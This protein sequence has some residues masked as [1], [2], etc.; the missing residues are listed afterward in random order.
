MTA[1]ITAGSPNV[2]VNGLKVARVSDTTDGVT[3]D[4]V[5]DIAGA[6]TGEVLGNMQQA[7]AWGSATL[8]SVNGAF[9]MSAPLTIPP[10]SGSSNT[11]NNMVPTIDLVQQ[12]IG[13][14][15]GGVTFPITIGQGG[16]G[17]NNTATSGN[18]L[19][20][21]GTAFKS[22]TLHGDA[23]VAANG[24]ILVSSSEGTAFGTAA[25]ANTTAFATDAEGNL[26]TS[27]V[28]P[29]DLATVAT[30]GAYND[31]SGKPTSLPPSGSAGGSLKGTYPNPTLTNTAVVAGT[32]GNT[33]YYGV[34]AV[35][36]DGRVTSANAYALPSGGGSP[37]GNAGGVLSGT[38]PN[39][40]IADPFTANTMTA[41]NLTIT[42]S[43]KLSS[44]TIVPGSGLI[45][46]ANS[47]GGLGGAYIQPGSGGGTFTIGTSSSIADVFAL[48]NSSGAIWTMSGPGVITTNASYSVSN[49]VTI[50][51]SANLYSFLINNGN[52]HP[53]H[54]GLQTAGGPLGN[55]FWD[56]TN[57]RF[58]GGIN[59]TTL[60]AVGGQVGGTWN[61]A[62]APPS[63]ALG[64][65]S[66]ILFGATFSSGWGGADLRARYD[67][68]ITFGPDNTSA[69]ARPWQMSFMVGNFTAD[70]PVTVMTLDGFGNLTPAGNVSSSAVLATNWFRSSGATGWYSTT[71]GGGVY[72]TDTTYV[73]AYNGKSMAAADFVISSD[74]KL[75]KDI[76][77]FE[78][79]GSLRPREFTWRHNGEHD[80]G[81]IAQEVE[82]M[83]P[84]CIGTMKDGDEET[85]QLSYQK[86]TAVLAAEIIELKR[87]IQLLKDRK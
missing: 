76:V 7:I 36:A 83:Y 74:A 40:G 72:M 16:T 62:M 6:V 69:Q 13:N 20:A 66:G 33:T 34:F 54:I 11:A 49:S 8:N 4:Q 14:S 85:K 19:V 58:N 79:R 23:T 73:R 52:T 59:T 48:A 67:G 86:L 37:T 87:E 63:V 77:D 26:A 38:Y 81:F 44:N 35:G 56:D 53:Y 12:M 60:S 10:F 39:P 65:A 45:Q 25:F 80:I 64:L 50:S 41:N 55:I 57:F 18:I 61:L 68:G 75:K 31:L 3:E 28:Q 15:S 46:A 24:L 22:T 43:L 9:Q 2:I 17:A 47:T 21:N 51:Q 30:T 82:A 71:Y 84:E 5:G 70:G 42:T 1:K 27:A 32:Y 29:S 78:L